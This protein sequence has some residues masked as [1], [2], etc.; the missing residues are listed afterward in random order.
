MVKLVYIVKLVTNIEHQWLAQ[1]YT[2]T[3]PE[4]NP[5][6]AQKIGKTYDQKNRNSTPTFATALDLHNF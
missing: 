2:D 3:Y 5:V 6:R 1:D 4:K